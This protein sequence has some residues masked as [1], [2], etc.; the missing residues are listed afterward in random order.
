MKEDSG[1]FSPEELET[2][3]LFF[4]DQAAT[5]L[6]NANQSLLR[7]ETRFD[8]VESLSQLQRTLHTL[9]GDANSVGFGEIG[10]VAHKLEDL[11]ALWGGVNVESTIE[12]LDLLLFGID[13]LTDM[14]ERKRQWVH[15]PL[16]IDSI[17]DR[18]EGFVGKH[19]KS[20]NLS[21]K[22]IDIEL[23]LNEY[24]K[25]RI[26]TALQNEP[27]ELCKLVARF[28]IDCSMHGAGLLILLR[29]I[30]RVGE[31]VASFPDIEDEQ[32]EELDKVIIILLAEDLPR[33][34]KVANVVGVTSEV[35]ITKIKV[36]DV[37]GLFS[38]QESKLLY[39]STEQD[40]PK[41]ISIDIDLSK[42]IDLSNKIVKPNNL[43]KEQTIETQNIIQQSKEN[44]AVEL[45]RV[46]VDKV[47]LLMD[48][49][50]EL[51]INRSMLNQISQ[52]LKTEFSKNPRINRL[53]DIDAQLGRLLGQMQKAV[54]EVRM[55]SLDQTFNRFFRVIRDLAKEGGKQIELLIIGEE[56]ELD[57]RVVDIIYEPLLHLVRNAVD[58]GIEPIE[59]R[60]K[61]NKSPQGKIIL[62]AYHQS[63]QVV[64]KIQDDGRGIDITKLKEKAVEKKL[65]TKAEIDLLSD[66]EA[67]DLMF[68]SGI[69]TASQITNVSGRGVG[70]D[71]VKMVVSDL[72]G[73]IEVSS[74]L[75]KSTVFTL[76][77][78]LTLAIIKAM[79]FSLGERVFALP[80]NSIVEIIRLNKE[81][82]QQIGK[83]KVLSKQDTLYS[84]IDL[85]AILLGNKQD[86]TNAI[87]LVIGLGERRIGVVVEK[88]I[89]EKEIV[90]KAVDQQW[91][92]SDLVTGASI[93]GDGRIVLIL[94]VGAIFRR[95]SLSVATK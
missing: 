21:D 78:P 38:E 31:I 9:K 87:T 36:A 67:Y 93:L 47:N 12:I 4:L 51:I 11:I 60:I 63:D 17:V 58:H 92:T 90:V 13:S 29:E 24:Q 43:A 59:E 2:L 30:S 86:Y 15:A 75:G 55:I 89:G 34:E 22:Q 57:K 49:V 74:V 52:Q 41:E 50:G 69:S 44:L 16:E 73:S 80:L 83:H 85:S 48:L 32:V 10:T 95:S 53:V 28:D 25:L 45:L 66:Q 40:K 79:L 7:L 39:Q 71:V 70:M 23:K 26:K 42:D 88:V 37:E 81:D 19:V 35:T 91:I 61:N 65:R 84:L 5:L 1:F 76:I 33:I 27:V 68:L 14:L 62:E 6:D 8:D 54:L 77:L 20:R 3:M 82:I 56:T 72:K 94:D 18:I 46:S 64:I